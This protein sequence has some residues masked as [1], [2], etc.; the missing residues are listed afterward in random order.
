MALRDDPALAHL[1]NP[2]WASLT[3]LHERLALRPSEGVARGSVGVARYPADVAPFLAIE[4]DG[5]CV[6]AALAEL[7]PPGDSVLCVGPRPA[8]PAGWRLEDFGSILQMVCEQA[9]PGAAP[10][11]VGEGEV[12]VHERLEGHVVEIDEAHRREAV[13]LAALVY[14]HYFR[15]RTPEMG[16]YFGIYRDGVLAAMAGE[17]MGWP[18]AREISAVCTR[19]AFV[20]RGL[21][22]RLMA[23]LVAD[24]ARSGAM[25]FLHVSPGNVR[26]RRLYERTGWRVR[27]EIA[28]CALHR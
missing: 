8:V 21:A 4:Q 18:G 25:A 13:E 15:P 7:V 1:D 24:L 3:T 14:P 2:L 11:E 10:G 12:A 16:R 23:H 20:G 5:A 19:P 17:R 26:A 6:D 28:F 9:L 22:R 27:R